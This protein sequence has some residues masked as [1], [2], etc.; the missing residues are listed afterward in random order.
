MKKVTTLKF[1]AITFALFSYSFG[2]SGGGTTTACAVSD[3][4]GDVTI[5]GPNAEIK[6]YYV[7]SSGSH[8]WTVP[9]GASI[10]GYG[11]NGNDSI[12][13]SFAPSY[14]TG[15]ITVRRQAAICANITKSITVTRLSCIM[16]ADAGNNAVVYYG[17]APL[18]CTNLSVTITNGTEPFDVQWSDGQNGMAINVCPS[19]TTTY[20]VNV[21]DANG[22]IASSSVSICAVDVV[23]YAGNSNVAKVE[24]CHPHAG[25][26]CVNA[27]AVPAQLA[28]G[29][30]LGSCDEVNACSDGGTSAIMI[31]QNTINEHNSALVEFVM[32]SEQEEIQVLNKMVETSYILYNMNG[33]IESKGILPLG[34]STVNVTNLKSGMYFI[35]T[36]KGENFKIVK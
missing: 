6:L 7:T 8:E 3:I 16:T 14:T 1:I 11:V 17:Y 27:D 36:E 18:A 20:V 31:G 21:T 34:Q 24:I 13:I 26:I 5:I 2:F 28:I 22:C 4:S 32:T 35:V 15:T 12:Y 23:C 25:N 29:G 33:Q 30:T 9:S 10:V 19:V